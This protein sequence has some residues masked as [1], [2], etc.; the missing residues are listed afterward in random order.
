MRPLLMLAFFLSLPAHAEPAAYLASQA[1]LAGHCWKGTFPDG[2]RTDQHCYEWVYAGQ[3]LRDRHTVRGRGTLY[4]GE[5]I[6][7]WDAQT[8]DVQSMSSADTAGAR[9][10]RRTAC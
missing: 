7:F 5:T 9:S 1:S 4:A 8:K 6:Y 3:V 10:R 2:A